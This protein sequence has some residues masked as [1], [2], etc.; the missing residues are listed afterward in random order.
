MLKGGL[1]NENRVLSKSGA[2]EMKGKE[3]WEAMRR[4]RLTGRDIAI[5]ASVV[6]LAVCCVCGGLAIAFVED[7]GYIL[8]TPFRWL[9]RLLSGEDLDLNLS[10]QAITVLQP[11]TNLVL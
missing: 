5:L 7:I 1:L 2:G 6:V 4:E 11:P 8:A 3:R 10:G 9:D